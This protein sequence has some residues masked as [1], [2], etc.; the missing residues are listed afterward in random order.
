MNTFLLR[1]TMMLLV[2]MTG[3]LVYAAG[4]IKG[5]VSFSG[6]GPKPRA[7]KMGADP[8][9]ASQHA[10]P[11]YSQA[12]VIN[13]NA[14]LK[15]VLV[16]IESGLAEKAYPVPEEPVVLN[17]LGCMYEPHVWGVRAGQVV[18]IQNS[19]ATLHNIHSLSKENSQFNFA[20]PKILKLKKH[21]FKKSEDVFKIKCDVHPWMSTFVG[22]FDHPFFAVTDDQ[23]SFVLEGVPDGDY[24]VRAW[25]ESKRLPAQT[26]TVKVSAGESATANF[27]FK[28]PQPK[29]K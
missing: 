18:E 3:Q 10:T 11:A 22:V 13:D 25:H 5:T 29:A 14:T 23:G 12:V 26:M 19:D 28:G 15:N 27:T 20:M 2:A 6:R 8:A 9:C 16:S 24:T 1:M 17:E 4:N 7:I 21:T